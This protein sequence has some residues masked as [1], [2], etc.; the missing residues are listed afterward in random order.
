MAKKSRKKRKN[1]T[2][3]EKVNILR[4]HLLDK[5]PVS[6]LCDEYELYPTQFYKWQKDFF[7]NGSVAFS[8]QH[9]NQEKRLR[10]Q[11]EKLKS[12]LTDKNEVVSELLEEHLKLKKTLGLI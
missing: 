10:E 6:D 3:G 8:N 9:S 7:E 12:K 1:Y 2:S 11:I 5:I 4:R